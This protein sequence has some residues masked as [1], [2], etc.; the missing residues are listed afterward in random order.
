[1]IKLLFRTKTLK[2][3]LSQFNLNF[4]LK[5]IYTCLRIIEPCEQQEGTPHCWFTPASHESVFNVAWLKTNKKPM[6][7]LTK[8]LRQSQTARKQAKEDKRSLFKHEWRVGKF[9]SHLGDKRAS[10]WNRIVTV[11]EKHIGFCQARQTQS[12]EFTSTVARTLSTLCDWIWCNNRSILGKQRWANR[13]TKEKLILS[14]I[15]PALRNIRWKRWVL[16]SGFYHPKL[17][18]SYPC[19]CSRHRFF[20]FHRISKQVRVTAL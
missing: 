1:M 11:I 7:G 20:F 2:P 6:T 17:K 12:H 15:Y 13:L 9:S 10:C 8:T 16:R 3:W 19:I 18:A 14:Q 4:I 5:P